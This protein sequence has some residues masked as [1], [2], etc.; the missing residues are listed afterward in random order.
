MKKYVIIESIG[1]WTIDKGRTVID[2]TVKEQHIIAESND[3][4]EVFTNTPKSVEYRKDGTWHSYS[5]D[6]RKSAKRMLGIK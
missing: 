1:T 6:S 2:C 4:M 3:F 5:Y